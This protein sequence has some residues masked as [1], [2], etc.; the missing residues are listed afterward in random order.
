MLN[1]GTVK[2]GAWVGI[3]DGARISYLVSGSDAEFHCGEDASGFDLAFES[4]ALRD[5]VRV[6]T[7]ALQA[8][9]AG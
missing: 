4:E 5:F 1:R 7:E 2:V 8:I 6:A 9:D 3:H